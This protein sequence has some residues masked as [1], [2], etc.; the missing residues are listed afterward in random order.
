M[1]GVTTRRTELPDDVEA[2]KSLVLAHRAEIDKKDSRIAHLEHNVEVYK[3]LA[4]G[5]SSER[6]TNAPKAD[7]NANQGYL[8]MLDLIEEA[9]R[10]AKAKDCAGSIGVEKPATTPRKGGGRKKLPP[11]LPVVRTVYE[12][13]GED[14]KCSC[15]GDLHEIGEDVREEL[16]RVEVLLVHK[17]ACKK[18]ACRQCQDGVRTAPGPDRVIEKGV[19]GK[20]FLAHVLTDR[21]CDHM[22][23]YRLEKKYGREGLAISR[24]VLQRSMTKLGELFEPLHEQLRQDVMES[25][26]VFTDDTPVTIA[27]SETGG[28]KKGRVWIYLDREGRHYYDFTGN[29]EQGGPQRIFGEYKGFIQADAYA[30]YDQL[31]L[32]GRA[33]EAA[34]WAHARRKFVDAETSDPDLARKAVDRIRELYQVEKFGKGMKDKAL[35]ELRRAK[36]KPILEELKAWLELKKVA[37]LPKSPIGKAIGYALNQWDALVRYADHGC[38]AIDN[39]AAE[40]AM[41]PFAVGR[42]NWLF[43][44]RNSG[45]RTA[46]VLASL[47]RTALAIGLDPHIYF[48]DLCTRISTESDVTK[49]VPHGWKEHYWPLLQK[50]RDEIVQRLLES[51]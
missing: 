42:K 24:S 4:F 19:L 21:F 48:R 16:E 12:L 35:A 43:F 10:T 8:F 25:E 14:R 2:L 18:Y 32:P 20:G 6:R 17:I 36:S 28:S 5:K 50:S 30:G 26:V 29:R 41:R 9:E 27:Q 47:L 22:P 49:L 45:G 1:S 39:N 34:C 37:V 51:R 33:T 15:G 38:L 7:S 23:Y 13:K 44:Q 11:H 46:S 40:Q 3:R 31:F